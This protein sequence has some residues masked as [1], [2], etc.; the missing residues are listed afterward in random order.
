M[1]YN[2]A[3]LVVFI[4]F[5]IKVFDPIGYKIVNKDDFLNIVEKLARGS[6][7][8]TSTLISKKFS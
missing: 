6:L 2:T 8:E 4:D 3:P 1:K 7:T 5:W